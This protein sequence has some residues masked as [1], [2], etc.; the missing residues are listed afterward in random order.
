MIHDFLSHAEAT[1]GLRGQFQQIFVFTEYTFK[2][3]DSKLLEAPLHYFKDVFLG[4]K[5]VAKIC[6]QFNVQLENVCISTSWL[7]Y[8]FLVKRLLPL[9]LRGF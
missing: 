7:Q 6:F 8:I 1:Q 4:H 3:G 2:I 9:R 5:I